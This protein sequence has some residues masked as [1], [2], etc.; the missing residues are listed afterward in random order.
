M[1][2]IVDSFDISK[3]LDLNSDFEVNISFG[4]VDRDEIKEA[5][6]EADHAFV[7]RVESGDNLKTIE[8]DL[9]LT[10]RNDPVTNI[11]LSATDCVYIAHI[12]PQGGNWYSFYIW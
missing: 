8:A 2:Y 9:E 7:A 6:D 11:S 5:I 10:I 3:L 1:I 4:K 12:T